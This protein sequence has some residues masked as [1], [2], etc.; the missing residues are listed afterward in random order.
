MKFTTLQEKYEQQ[1]G[2]SIDD[3]SMLI[4]KI[5][6]NCSE[7]LEQAIKGTRIHYASKSKVGMA[8]LRPSASTSPDGEYHLLND[9]VDNAPEWSKFPK[10]AVS[11]ICSTATEAASKDDSVYIVLPVNGAKIGVCTDDHYYTSFNRL[12]KRYDVKDAGEFEKRFKALLES[13]NN[14]VH[15]QSPAEWNNEAVK[16]ICG[17]FDNIQKTIKGVHE[18]ETYYH[19]TTEDNI[20]RWTK[21]YSGNLYADVLDALDP[22]LNGFKCIKI[23]ELTEKNREVW[24][25]NECYLVNK[26]KFTKL[27]DSGKLAHIGTKE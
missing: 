7:A 10:R 4:Q 12:E 24:F 21:N 18:F 9:L 19:T 11:A 27:V 26:Y 22:E 23:T 6:T 13:V 16:Q 3:E 20:K 2:K 25:T 5:K 17:M 1:L 14:F 15:E 8:L